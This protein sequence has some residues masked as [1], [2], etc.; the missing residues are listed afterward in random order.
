MKNKA[1]GEILSTALKKA[2]DE[3]V[4]LA[5]IKAMNKGRTSWLARNL[6]VTPTAAANYLAGRAIPRPP[7]LSKLNA[8]FEKKEGYF[9]ALLSSKSLKA[10]NISKD[11]LASTTIP[12]L[13]FEILGNS[14]DL[15]KY[16]TGGNKMTFEVL[17]KDCF[18][19]KLVTD[20]MESKSGVSLPNG[21]VIIVDKS[22]K[23]KSGNIVIYRQ[24]IEKNSG[25]GVLF[26][27]KDK[28]K[29]IKYLNK[30]FTTIEIDDSF[31]IIGVCKR[32]V[33]DIPTIS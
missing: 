2:F 12:V 24:K 4:D 13:N 3:I 28:A 5:T 26:I 22:A 25:I 14:E 10:F 32:Q 1:S 17:N 30:K 27:D 16:F 21:S 18:S 11:L 9:S 8:I 6:D 15:T 7:I 33:Y 20:S 29:Y 19:I 31:E 23:P